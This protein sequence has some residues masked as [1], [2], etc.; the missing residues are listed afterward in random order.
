MF[1]VAFLDAVISRL[2]NER[3]VIEKSSDTAVG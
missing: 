2:S 1:S 3:P